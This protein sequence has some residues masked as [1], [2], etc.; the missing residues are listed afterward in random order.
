MRSVGQDL[1]VKEGSGPTAVTAY[2]LVRYNT[3][4]MCSNPDIG[5][6]YS[7]KLLRHIK[8]QCVARGLTTG[9]S[10]D[11]HKGKNYAP[12]HAM[13][14]YRGVE[15]NSQVQTPVTLLPGTDTGTH[16]EGR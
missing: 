12:V 1:A 13:T 11:Q 9:R 2:V 8:V 7:I 15:V 6:G 10:P 5:R 4:I 14:A 16:S 3:R